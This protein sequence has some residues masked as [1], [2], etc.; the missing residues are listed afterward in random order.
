MESIEISDIMLSCLTA[1]LRALKTFFEWTA[2]CEASI[3]TNNKL[4]YAP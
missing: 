1:W 2:L 3:E 4:V